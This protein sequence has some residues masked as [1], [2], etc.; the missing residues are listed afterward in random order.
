MKPMV[1]FCDFRCPKV[2][3]NEKGGGLLHLGLALGP[4]SQSPLGTGRSP[5]NAEPWPCFPEDREKLGSVYHK[6]SYPPTWPRWSEHAVRTLDHNFLE[7]PSTLSNTIMISC[8]GSLGEFCSFLGKDLTS[9]SWAEHPLLGPCR[10]CFSS[11]LWY[12]Y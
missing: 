11:P 12:V 9:P 8:K 4:S 6:L 2:L 1:L 10:K 5:S 7:V 3:R